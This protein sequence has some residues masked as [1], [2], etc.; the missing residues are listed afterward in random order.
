MLELNNSYFGIYYDFVNLLI[1]LVFILI[2]YKKNFIN[3]IG[4]I[5]LSLFSLTPIFG[6]NVLF[7]FNIFPDQSKYIINVSI[8]RNNYLAIIGEIFSG[9]ID[10][11]NER[12]SLILGERYKPTRLTSLF[13]ASIPLPFNETVRSIGLFS[14]LIFIAWFVYL[15]I[16]E[17]KILKKENY[18]YY[19]ILILPSILIYSSLAL[20]EI[21][22]FVF[23]HLCMYF[24]LNRKIILFIISLLILT[25]LR[26]ELLFI[27]SVFSLLYIFIFY[28]IPENI[29]S[30]NKQNLFKILFAIIILFIVTIF[31]IDFSLINENL[32]LLVERINDMKMGYHMEGDATKELRL[33]SYDFSILPMIKDFINALLSP[34][35]SKS[36]NIF[37][38]FFIFENCL[39]N[40]LFILYFIGISK[41]NFLKSIFYLIFFL[42]LNLA[43]GLFV[44]NDIAIYRYKITMIIPLVLIMRE[45]I[46]NYKNENI[47]FNKS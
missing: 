35:F 43:V 47:I 7:D 21:Y 4:L 19:L 1:I 8:I 14:K 30:K 32:N 40:I 9:D 34:S 16:N 28:Y 11:F 37:L 20:K 12:F 38:Y 26:F 23:F 42:I 46:L 31:L 2:I 13:I 18:Y 17:K 27:I 25:I 15:I 5:T 10:S 24:I 6:N 3:Q 33:Y 39:I 22:I 29:L 36:D 45:E 44:I 41:H